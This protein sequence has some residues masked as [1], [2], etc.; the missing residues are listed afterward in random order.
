[1]RKSRLI[2]GLS[3]ALA[4]GSAFGAGL[5]WDKAPQPEP[6]KYL[7]I[8]MK[9][10]DPEDAARAVYGLGKLDGRLRG[11]VRIRVK[12]EPGIS[13]EEAIKKLHA[14]DQV[15]MAMEMS[16]FDEIVFH[17]TSLDVMKK[18]VAYLRE[19]A[20]ARP[21]SEKDEVLEL[22]KIRNPVTQAEV[23]PEVVLPEG[24]VVKRGSMA[25]SKVFRLDG[26]AP[27]DYSGQYAAFGRFEYA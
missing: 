4:F 17:S 15:A 10:D 16:Q 23:H 3:L 14:N 6:A 27:Y 26:D 13:Q 25:A 11:D 12:L 18:R 22:Q 19:K 2:C 24:L 1:M 9:S 7:L 21:Q 5:P 20:D 8:R